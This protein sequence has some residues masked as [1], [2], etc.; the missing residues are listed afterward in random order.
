VKVAFLGTPRAAVATLTAIFTAGHDVALV[1]TQPEKPVG[2]SGALR[3]TPVKEAATRNGATVVEPASVRT[4]SFLELLKAT[5]PDVLVVVAYGKLLPAAVLNVAPM[6]TLN[7]HFSLLPAYR[8][9]APV[10]WAL[11]RGETTTGVTTMRV[12]EKLD[13]G[14]ILLQK[15]VAIEPGEHAPS[16]LERL[17]REGANLLLTTLRYLESGRLVPRP[18][19]DTRASYAP[20][21]RPADGEVAFSLSAREIEGRVRGFDPWPGVW[22]LRGPRRVRLVEARAREARSS[23]AL[24]GTVVGYEDGALL[25]ACGAGSVLEVTAVQ[26]EGRRTIT[27]AEAVNGRQIVLGDVLEGRAR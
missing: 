24:P 7:V 8:G 3:P 2:R 20:R 22:A 25:V 11:A 10:Q 14:D 9:A 23:E 5:A 26:V 19:D 15:E 12:G 27:A 21:L 18:Q 4:E 1:V 16:L 17:A 13:Q 6:G